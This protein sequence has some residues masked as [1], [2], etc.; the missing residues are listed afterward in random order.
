MGRHGS[1]QVKAREAEQAKDR[2]Q[3]DPVREAEN[4]CEHGVEMTETEQRV[5]HKR[6]QVNPRS[7]EMSDYQMAI[8][9]DVPNPS[10]TDTT[11]K[12]RMTNTRK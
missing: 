12:E 8:E 3:V 10:N 4:T 5:I 9:N 7:A 2:P 1:K 11:K 6:T